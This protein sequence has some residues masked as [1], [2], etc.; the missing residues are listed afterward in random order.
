MV[1]RANKARTYL[2]TFRKLAKKC[3]H[4]QAS[5]VLNDLV[6]TTPGSEGKWFV[7]ATDAGPF[8]GAL[9]LMTKSPADPKSLARGTGLRQEETGVRR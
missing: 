7:A 1:L 4:Q 5:E 6:A 3:P 8:E 9:V 2:A